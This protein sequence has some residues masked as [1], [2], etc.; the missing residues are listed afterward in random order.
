MV[1]PSFVQLVPGKGDTMESWF[2]VGGAD[3][4]A[5]RLLADGK[6]KPCIITTSTLEFMQGASRMPGFGVKTLKADDYRTWSE[7]RRALVKLLLDINKEERPAF[8]GMRGQGFGG[9]GFGG[10]GRFGGDN[11]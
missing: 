4:I 6:T 7:R 9:P 1:M 10:G 5:D 8:P 2:K 11:F 3:A